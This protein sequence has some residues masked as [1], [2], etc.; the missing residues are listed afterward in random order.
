MEETVHHVS[1]PNSYRR[2]KGLSVEEFC[3]N[4]VQEL[5][6]TILKIGPDQVACFIAEPI[7]GSGG[8]LV[9]PE[10]YHKRTLEVCRKY[11]V[12]YISDEVV[13]GFGRLGHFFSSEE[14]WGIVPDIITCAKG[15]SSGY[16]PLGAVL[17]SDRLFEAISGENA[18]ENPCFTNGYTYSGH[19]VACA[20]G[21][22]NIEIMKRD[23]ICEH[24]R[25]IGPYFMEQLKT[26]ERFDIVG[27]VRGNHLMACVECNISGNPYAAEDVDMQA[28]GIVDKHCDALGLIVR[29]YEALCILSPPLIIDKQGVDTLV[30]I[31]AQSIE[32][33][34]ADLA[35]QGL[36][37]K[38][39]A[40]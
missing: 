21:L 23:K 32:K 36:L 38:G 3:N 10:G 27:E 11:D 30:S 40:Q 1:S 5:E 33:A 9:P 28:A 19:P 34:T 39:A 12:L 29:P 35:A 14:V 2:E 22:K 18:R 25:D 6:D 13:T 26:L 37:N 7:L 4:L 15:L 24:V 20:A 8:V 16:Q 17:I 31:L